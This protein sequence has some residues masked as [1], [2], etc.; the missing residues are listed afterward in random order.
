MDGLL[1]GMAVSDVS[2]QLW[3]SEPLKFHKT[4]ALQLEEKFY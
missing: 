3:I 4:D 2:S 1:S